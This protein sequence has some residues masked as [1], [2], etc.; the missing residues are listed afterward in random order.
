MREDINSLIKKENKE[1]ILSELR[2]N[3]EGLNTSKLNDKL[4]ISHTTINKHLNELEEEGKVKR[5]WKGQSKISFLTEKYLKS[6]KARARFT[7]EVFYENLLDE[8]ILRELDK[9]D[10]LR[11]LNKVNKWLKM[12]P[13]RIYSEYL[14]ES[15]KKRDVTKY[16]REKRREMKRKGEKGFIKGVE[17]D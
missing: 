14:S 2:A 15:V 6:P 4:D 7:A 8:L 17:S 3:P 16:V 1:K 5:E 13:E 9:E 11:F 10:R 12:D